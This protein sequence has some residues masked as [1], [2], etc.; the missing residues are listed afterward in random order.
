M[1]SDRFLHAVAAKGRSAM[2]SGGGVVV[3]VPL[4]TLSFILLQ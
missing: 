2:W 3:W 1:P 4:Y